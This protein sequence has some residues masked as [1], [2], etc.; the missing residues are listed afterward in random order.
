MGN[1]LTHFAVNALKTMICHAYLCVYYLKKNNLMIFSIHTRVDKLMICV[2]L[3]LRYAYQ[4]NG[5][6]ENSTRKRFNKISIKNAKL[7]ISVINVNI[8]SIAVQ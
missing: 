3:I 5:A 8:K 4:I 1:N 6:K 2:S 7:T